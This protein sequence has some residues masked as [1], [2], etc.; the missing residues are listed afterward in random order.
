PKATVHGWPRRKDWSAIPLAE[1]VDFQ[2][3]AGSLPLY[4]RN[5]TEDFPKKKAFLVPDPATVAQW[6]QCFAALG[7]GLKVGLSWRAGGKANEGRKRTIS[8]LDWHEILT[9]PGVQFI[10]LQYGDT[11]EDAAEVER[12][13]GVRIHDWEQGDPLV[14][15]DS[16]TAKIAALDLVIS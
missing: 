4:F 16:Y 12:E 9:T 1:P 3:P 2:I 15:V 7:G 13:L 11:S 8:L 6:K 10:N 5:R 14:D